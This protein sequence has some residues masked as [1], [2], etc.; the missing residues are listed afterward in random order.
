MIAQYR[1][2]RATGVE[3]L[4]CRAKYPFE[5]VFI[6]HSGNGSLGA[7]RQRADHASRAVHQD[8][9]I[10]AEHRGRKYDAELNDGANFEPD[11][12]MEQNAARGNIRGFGEEF[13]CIGSAHG[14][15][16]PERKSD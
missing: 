6:D 15:R 12:G 8:V 10:R 3:E 16:K 14:Y 1:R 4:H 2:L 13:A 7:L 11:L 5:A 9:T